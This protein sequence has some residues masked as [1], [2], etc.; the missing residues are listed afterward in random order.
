MDTNLFVLNRDQTLFT[1]M[2]HTISFFKDVPV[3][4]PDVCIPLALSI[5]AVLHEPTDAEPEAVAKT[6]KAAPESKPEP[7]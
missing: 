1:T 4:V 3:H 2:G 7:A 5:G 6:K